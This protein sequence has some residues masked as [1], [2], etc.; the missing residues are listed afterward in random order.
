MSFSHSSVD[1]IGNSP[2][3]NF[4]GSRFGTETVDVTGGFSSDHL[5]YFTLLGSMSLP[6][7]SLQLQDLQ[8][9]EPDRTCNHWMII[10]YFIPPSPYK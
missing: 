2:T 8:E 1:Q 10:F 3:Q 7:W 4:T 6:Q 5:E 9:N